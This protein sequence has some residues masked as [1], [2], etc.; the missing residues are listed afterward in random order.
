M[1]GEDQNHS[2]LRVADEDFLQDFQLVDEDEVTF[3][4]L[5]DVNVF[6]EQLL[7]VTGTQLPNQREKSLILLT[8]VV[9]NCHLSFICYES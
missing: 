7:S 3:V 8:K 5:T 4:H 2:F 6:T 9:S 1:H